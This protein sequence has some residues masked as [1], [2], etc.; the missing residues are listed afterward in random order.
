MALTN[1]SFVIS[2][3]P[4]LYSTHFKALLRGLGAVIPPA[5]RPRHQR[6]TNFFPNLPLNEGVCC[7]LKVTVL[8]SL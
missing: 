5:Q 2:Q 1:A 8:L 4:G 3:R 6:I 7:S